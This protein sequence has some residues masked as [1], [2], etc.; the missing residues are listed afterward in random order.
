MGLYGDEHPVKEEQIFKTII[1]DAL[2]TL[3]KS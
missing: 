2:Q 1:D 3:E